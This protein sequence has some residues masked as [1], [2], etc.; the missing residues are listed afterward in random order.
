MTLNE[1]NRSV[2]FYPDVDSGSVGTFRVPRGPSVGAS[3][4]S[5]RQKSGIWDH[6]EKAPDYASSRKANCIR[7]DKSYV[8][9]NGSTKNMWNHVKNAHP[10]AFSVPVPA[11]APERFFDEASGPLLYSEDGFKKDLVGLVTIEYMPFIVAESRVFRMMVERLR[12]GATVPSATTVKRAVMAMF[13]DERARWRAILQE[14]PGTISFTVDMWTAP[15]MEPFLGITAHWI[16][17]EWRLQSVLL[18]L[19]SIEGPH[20][21]EELCEAFV[22]V[23]LEFGILTKLLAVTTDN[24]SNNDTFLERLES[25]CKQRGISF[26]KE[27]NHV[28]CMAH[29]INLAAQ[30]FLK[31]LKAE[32]PS[33]KDDA[34]VGD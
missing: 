27:D 25:I 3:R 19:V 23:C 29:V 20:R 5:S 28:R 14:V 9:S 33:T 11:G 18:D 2:S 22:D 7:C 26:T 4:A 21:G 31:A 10:D 1:S 30:A 13:H 16:N 6:F 17:K 34:T 15:N 24:A 8:C 32:P 12:P